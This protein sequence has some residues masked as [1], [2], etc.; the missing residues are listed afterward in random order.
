MF[1]ETEP[2]VELPGRHG[3]HPA[4]FISEG[5]CCNDANRFISANAY[6][7]HVACFHCYQETRVSLN[8]VF[9][10]S[11]SRGK[12]AR[13]WWIWFVPWQ[14]S[15]SELTADG[16][17]CPHRQRQPRPH[18]QAGRWLGMAGRAS[19]RVASGFAVG[20]RAQLGGPARAAASALC[21]W[22][23]SGSVSSLELRAPRL[24]IRDFNT[25][26]IRI[27]TSSVV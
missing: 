14:Q 12:R 17:T 23:R 7:G 9:G 3:T 22:P 19:Q 24:W 20:R 18:S 6:D 5:L 15:A 10:R 1:R 25:C 16:A 13:L 8:D 27:G 2:S 26:G 4:R 11:L 21:A